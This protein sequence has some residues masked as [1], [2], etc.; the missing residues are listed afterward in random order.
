MVAAGARDSS[1]GLAQLSSFRRRPQL[2]ADVSG[3][4]PTPETVGTGWVVRVPTELSVRR[5]RSDMTQIAE[6]LSYRPLFYSRPCWAQ[7]RASN[8]SR[9]MGNITTY[10]ILWLP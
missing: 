5:R 6:A 4:P 10:I 3:R 8:W 2:Q 9:G 7:T 1:V